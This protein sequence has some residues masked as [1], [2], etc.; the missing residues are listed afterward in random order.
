MRS[1][2]IFSF[3][4]GVAVLGAVAAYIEVT[5]T[6]A[7]PSDRVVKPTGAPPPS[8]N[9]AKPREN[10]TV[11]TAAR[12]ADPSIENP[13]GNPLWALPLKQLSATL[14]RPIFSQSRRRPPAP[15]AHVVPVAVRP[16]PKPAE[17]D[18][19]A[20]TLLGTIVGDAERIGVFLEP[21]T[22]NIVRMRVGEDHQGW[23]LREIKAREV[24]LAKNNEQTVL[25]LPPPGG[26]P[27][28]ML[29]NQLTPGA[30]Q[31]APGVPFVPNGQ[32]VPNAQAGRRPPQQPQQRR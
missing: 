28:T 26:E 27:P 2:R 16:P 13:P 7:Q 15:T 6:T 30:P 3:L 14:E 19:P 20:V 32:V 12:P 1:R 5:R 11:R 18:R 4:A 21:T 29:A 17:P 25:E 23:V 8:D 9:A 22:R 31:F 10:N 24:T